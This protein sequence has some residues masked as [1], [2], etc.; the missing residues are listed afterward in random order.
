MK[1]IT[2]SYKK[3]TDSGNPGYGLV[4]YELVAD[5]SF[6]EEIQK[7]EAKCRYR[8]YNHSSFLRHLRTASERLSV[9]NQKERKGIVFRYCPTEHFASAYKFTPETTQVILKST[10]KDKEWTVTT[11]N[12]GNARANS[13][14][15]QGAIIVEKQAVKEK[16]MNYYLTV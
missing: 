2:I 8:L 16:L 15:G 11:I 13:T 6:F 9:L 4:S 3:N 7:V 1:K 14:S 10:G 5:R 12:R